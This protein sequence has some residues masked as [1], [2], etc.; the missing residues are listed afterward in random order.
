[1]TKHFDEIHLR[2][3]ILIKMSYIQSNIPLQVNNAI[4]SVFESFRILTTQR[5]ENQIK[6]ALFRFYFTHFPFI[7]L[8]P[9]QRSFQSFSLPFSFAIRERIL[10]L[11]CRPSILVRQTVFLNLFNQQ[12]SRKIV[13][14][15]CIFLVPS[16]ITTIHFCN[17]R[18]ETTYLRHPSAKQ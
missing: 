7:F 4:L 8:T 10:L 14:K 6:I 3:D 13:R 15:R 16:T 2:Q 11:C 17:F 1:M 18:S 9:P 5:T 12:F